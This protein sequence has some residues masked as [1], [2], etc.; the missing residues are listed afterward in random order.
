MKTVMCQKEIAIYCQYSYT[1]FFEGKAND[2]IRTIDHVLSSD[3]NAA[4]LCI[5][6][7]KNFMFFQE[8]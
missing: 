3:I 8:P 1:A 2:L 7:I 4:M 6:I 5:I